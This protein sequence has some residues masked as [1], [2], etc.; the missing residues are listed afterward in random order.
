MMTMDI[1][2]LNLQWRLRPHGA[3]HPRHEWRS[4]TTRRRRNGLTTDP[5]P[6]RRVL[7]DVRE[8]DPKIELAEPLLVDDSDDHQIDAALENFVDDS[9]TDITRLKQIRMNR[10]A[11]ALA[12]LFGL[13]QEIL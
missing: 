12:D 4:P 2:V 11:D 9:R 13:V 10:H 1:T 3:W 6:T 8:R 5:D 7:Q